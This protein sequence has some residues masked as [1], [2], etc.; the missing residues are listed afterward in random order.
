MG[1]GKT[2]LKDLSRSVRGRRVLVTGGASGMGRATAWLFA[3][4][5]AIVALTDIDAE[6][7]EE[8][9]RG[10]RDEGHDARAWMLDA[11]DRDSIHATVPEIARA[12]GGLDIIVN[13]AGISAKVPF[14]APDYDANWDRN[15][16]VTL[17]GQQAV[18]RA[19]IPFL[20]E[21]DAPRIVNIASTEALGASAGFSAYSAAKAG[22]I[23]LT[24]SFAVELGRRG[25]TVN[26]LCPGPILTGMTGH[27]SEEDR[28]TFA[29]RRTALRRYGDPME[30]AHITLSLALPAASYITGAVIPV[31]GG[32][33]TRH[34]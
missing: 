31:D 29:R 33:S 15:I 12:L 9:A 22:V 5:G 2:P 3:R 1:F 32:L 20:T 27:L 26:C 17:T 10:I 23:G 13:N 28:A 4:E 34:A 14:D 30:V 6:G 25:I 21:S 8:V 19:A 16:A 7:A 24:R 18:I 11:G